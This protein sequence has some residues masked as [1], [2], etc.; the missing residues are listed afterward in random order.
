MAKIP[1]IDGQVEIPVIRERKV[2]L[3]LRQLDSITSDIRLAQYFFDI[4]N[5]D[6]GVTTDV[7]LHTAKFAI[8][9]LPVVP[10]RDRPVL[11]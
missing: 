8:A 3:S 5:A 9:H 2:V 6:L 4:V 10:P 11:A 1:Q 7:A